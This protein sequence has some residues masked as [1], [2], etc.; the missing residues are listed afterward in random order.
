MGLVDTI[1]IGFPKT[2]TT[3]VQ[4]EVIPNVPGM[5]S[6]GKPELIDPEYRVLFNELVSCNEFDFSPENFIDR[7]RRLEE[8]NREQLPPERKKII[9]F[10]LLSGE[11]YAGLDAKQ[12]LDRIKAVFG[13]PQ[14]IIT[15]RHQNTI[16]E[17]IFK[18]YV[19]SGGSLHIRE[20]V[21]KVMSPSVDIWGNRHLFTKFRYDRMV[22]Y[23]Q[24][25]FGRDK[26]KVIPFE[27]IKSA[28][29]LFIGAFLGFMGIEVVAGINRKSRVKNPGMSY[30]GIVLL[31][32]VN[33]LIST[34]LSDSP[35]LRS[36][37]FVYTRFI[38][39]IFQPLDR[40]FLSKISPKKKFVDFK[41][42]WWMRRTAKWFLARAWGQESLGAENRRWATN[43][44]KFMNWPDIESFELAERGERIAEEIEA[45]Y[46]Q[47]NRELAELTGIPLEDLG[48]PM[49]LSVREEAQDSEEKMGGGGR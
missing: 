1:H 4:E 34:P 33:Q 23:C 7:F 10:E 28:P 38:H 47:P 32:L 39:K 36:V 43:L 26:V 2:G 11:I 19:A 5:A 49:A 9:S 14:I 44:V 31:R 15:V 42:R 41:K 22:S 27:W 45:V 12:L 3:W 35:F 24:E 29:E 6:L 17:S 21:Y 46:A 40:F 8:K 20:F 48:Y 25:V 37:P 13:T 16:I 30:L 18:H